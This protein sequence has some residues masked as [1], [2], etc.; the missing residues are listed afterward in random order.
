MITGGANQLN[1]GRVEVPPGLLTVTPPVAP[2]PTTACMLVDELTV[3]DKA[4]TPPIVTPV[5]PD[6]DVPVI[7][8]MV[9]WVPCI[10]V[11]AVTV[12]RLIYPGNVAV[13]P[14]VVTLT[15]PDGPDGATAVMVVADTT[16]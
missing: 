11:N 2:V 15:L 13:P 14:G 16:L 5:A 3:N 10:G 6:K 7:F 12:G 9:P 1:P 8:K 4:L